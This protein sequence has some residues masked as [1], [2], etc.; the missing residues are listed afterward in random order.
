MNHYPIRTYYI[1][2]LSYIV[3]Y[4]CQGPMDFDEKILPIRPRLEPVT[5]Q[6]SISFLVSLFRFESVLLVY[7]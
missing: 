5:I 2:G 4:R 1:R 6:V 7:V 3:L